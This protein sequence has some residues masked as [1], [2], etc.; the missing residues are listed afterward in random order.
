MLPAWKQQTSVHFL[1][2]V[3]IWSTDT[4]TNPKHWYGT[5]NNETV[6]YNDYRTAYLLEFTEKPEVCIF[7]FKLNTM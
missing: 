5:D 7:E 2:H 1:H 3:F 4:V 6:I